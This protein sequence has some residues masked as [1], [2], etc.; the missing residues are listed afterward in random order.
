MNEDKEL[1]LEQR[2]S[3]NTERLDKLAKIGWTIFYGVVIALV[4]EVIIEVI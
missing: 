3:E 1:S 2:V 4:V